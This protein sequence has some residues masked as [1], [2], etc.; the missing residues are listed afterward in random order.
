M[1]DPARNGATRPR[2]HRVEFILVGLTVLAALALVWGYFYYY[3]ERLGPEQPIHFSHRIHATERGISCLFCHPG[4]M[5]TPR[6]GIPPLET[7]LL[8]HSRIIVDYPE[9]LKLRASYDENKPVEWVRVNTLP[10][11][12]YFDHQA[13]IRAGFDCGHCHGD[14]AAMDRV[15]LVHDFQMGFCVQ[16]H[17]DNHFSHDCLICHR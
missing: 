4:A 8:C 5:N 3:P 11:F 12:V 9:I 15:R 16:C 17:R 10:D 1:T 6:A 14:V 7:C 13:H 2:K